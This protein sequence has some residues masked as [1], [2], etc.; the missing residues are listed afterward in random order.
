METTS[1]SLATSTMKLPATEIV[2]LLADSEC[3]SEHVQDILEGYTRSDAVEESQL[4]EIE[5]GS[6]GDDS[7]EWGTE[8]LYEEFLEAGEDH[9][10]VQGIWKRCPAPLES[11]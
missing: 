1:R 3:E 5:G 2:D 11:S 8:S 7:E 4:G 10:A 9:A 6:E